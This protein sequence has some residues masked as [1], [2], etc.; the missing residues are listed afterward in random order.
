MKYE[1]DRAASYNEV[2]WGEYRGTVG[3]EINLHKI[4]KCAVV[5]AHRIRGHPPIILYY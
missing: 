1:V 4:V 3:F 2:A 5:F